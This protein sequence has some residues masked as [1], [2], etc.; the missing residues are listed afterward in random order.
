MPHLVTCE[1]GP[2][3][4]KWTLMCTAELGPGALYGVS[5]R[6]PCPSLGPGSDWKPHAHCAGAETEAQRRAGAS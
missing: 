2:Q 6:G 4:L 1:T 3:Q 5:T